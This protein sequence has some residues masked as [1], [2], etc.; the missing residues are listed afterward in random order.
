MQTCGQQAAFSFGN[1]FNSTFSIDEVTKTGR[2]NRKKEMNTSKHTSCSSKISGTVN[3]MIWQFVT[4]TQIKFSRV[5][6][7]KYT[8]TASNLCGLLL[9]R[10]H[11]LFLALLAQV[12]AIYSFASAVLIFDFLSVAAIVFALCIID[13]CCCLSLWSL[14]LARLLFEH[15]T[16]HTFHTCNV[17]GRCPDLFARFAQ[18]AHW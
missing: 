16:T 17:F 1:M 15:C 13:F 18:T 9:I 6:R 5:P 4:W 3:K 14:L 11:S 8:R 10:A 7:P 2:R 12:A